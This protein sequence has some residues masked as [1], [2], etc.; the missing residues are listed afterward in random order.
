MVPGDLIITVINDDDPCGT[1]T[2]KT[3]HID[4]SVVNS[5]QVNASG[6]VKFSAVPAGPYTYNL[7]DTIFCQSESPPVSYGRGIGNNSGRSPRQCPSVPVLAIQEVSF[8]GNN[9]VD[10]DTTGPFPSP[11]W[12]NGAASQAPVSYSRNKNISFTAKFNVTTAPLCAEQVAIKATATF[13]SASLEWDA[14]ITVSPGD[15]TASASL[16]S[17][18]PLANEI[19]IFESSSITWQIN[20]VNKGWQ[21][22]GTTSNVLYVTLGDPSGSPNYWT[23]LDISCRGAAGKSNENDFIS[24]SFVPFRS[25]IGDGNGFKRKRDGAQLTYYKNGAGTPSTSVFSCSDLLSRADGTGRCGAWARFMVAMHQVHGVTSSSSTWR[26]ARRRKSSDCQELH[27]QR[28][29]QPPSAVSVQG[30]CRMRQERWHLWTGQ[31]QPPMHVR[32]PRAREALD[33]H[34]RSILWSRAGDGCANLDERWYRG[35]RNG[36]RGQ[37]HIRRRSPLSAQRLQQDNH[38]YNHRSM[39][40]TSGKHYAAFALLFSVGC[41]RYNMTD[42]K[43]DLKFASLDVAKAGRVN[44]IRL[45][46]DGGGASLATLS[47]ASGG[48]PWIDVSNLAVQ[49]QARRLFELESPFGGPSWDLAPSQPGFAAVWTT[50][51]E[52]HMSIGFPRL[53]WNC[54]RPYRPLSIRCFSKAAVRAR[55]VGSFSG[56]DRLGG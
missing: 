19:G 2:G 17:N 6:Q 38:S 43:I 4:G 52:R 44:S 34:L 56:R 26:K 33:R 49:S 28:S 35:D 18:N 15:T 54:R 11:E 55:W 25:T 47:N 3:V 7:T 1:V 5:G 13:G 23:L 12:K 32:R 42:T 21:A 40:R 48:A 14:T 41:P 24:A 16:T 8:T 31:E 36:A 10:N 22:A 53:R 37:F 29:G 39:R 51:R 45:V 46:M 50:S 30:Q 20:P 9:P 27:V